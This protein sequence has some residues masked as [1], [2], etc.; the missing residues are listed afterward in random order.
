MTTLK[1]NVPANRLTTLA[2]R[3]CYVFITGLGVDTE[4]VVPPAKG[5]DIHVNKVIYSYRSNRAGKGH[6]VQRGA[7]K[8]KTAMWGSK[9]TGNQGAFIYA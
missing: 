5:A 7:S 1:A 2:E 3:I 6:M 4:G 9:R 8:S